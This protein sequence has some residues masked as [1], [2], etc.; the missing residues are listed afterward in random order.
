MRRKT[1]VLLGALGALSPILL[2]PVALS[3]AVVIVLIPSSVILIV[4]IALLNQEVN[5]RLINLITAIP[6][7]R[8]QK[9]LTKR[10]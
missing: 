4:V 1:L 8:R 5:S 3:L 2:Q 7:Q 6:S 10:N 9:A